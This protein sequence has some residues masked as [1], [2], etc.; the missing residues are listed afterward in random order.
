VFDEYTTILIRI[1]PKDDTSGTYPV[2]ATL[3]DGD[4]YPGGELR[5]DWEQLRLQQLDPLGY[6]RLLADALFAGPI[7]EA[8]ITVASRA[9][10]AA[11]GRVR[12]RLWIDSRAAE[13]HALPWERLY[14][15]QKNKLVP[16]PTT[17]R[18]PFSRYLAVRNG[19][20]Q[21]IRRS[22]IHLLFA[23][24]NPSDLAS[25]LRLAPVDVEAEV[26]NLLQ[27]L[28]ELRSSHRFQVTIMPGQTGLSPDLQSRLEQEGYR[29]REGVTSLDGILRALPGCGLVHF[30]GHGNLGPDGVAVLH[31][32]KEDGTWE[33]VT[34]DE[35][36]TGLAAT[37]PLPHLIFLAACESG[38]R[39][40]AETLSV[41]GE[42]HPF[43]GLA[44]KLLQAGV[45]AVVAMQDVVPMD[46]VRQLTADFYRNLL[47]H[48]QI[49]LAVNQARLLLFDTDKVD[50]AIPVLFSRLIDNDLVDFPSLPSLQRTHELVEATGTLLTAA[51]S[52]AHGPELVEELERLFEGWQKSYQGLA[53]LESALRRTGDNPETFAVRFGEFYHEFKDYYNSETWLDEQSLIQ[54]TKRLR[55]RVLPQMEPQMDGA[56]F[57]QVRDA[58]DQH[59]FA[60]GQLAM[61][62]QEF[63]EAM[64]GVVIEIR[65]RLDSGDVEG[66]IH[67][68]REF[69][70]QHASSLAGSRKLLQMMSTQIMTVDDLVTRME[71]VKGPD[72]VVSK[73]DLINTVLVQDDRQHVFGQI[74]QRVMDAQ[75]V[76]ERVLQSP[77]TADVPQHVASQID[78][79]LAAQRGI[80]ARGILLPPETLH[81]LGMLAAYRRDYDTAVSYFR[82]ATEADPGYVAAFQA[83]A[84][85]QQSRAMHDLK[86]GGYDAALAKLAE[87]RAASSH[88]PTDRAQ[89]S[90]GYIAKTQAQ[91]AA[92]TDRPDDYQSYLQ[93]AARLFQQALEL[94]PHSAE[95]HNG[96]GNIYYML[97]DYDAAVGALDQAVQLNPNYTAAYHDLGAACMAQMGADPAQATKWCQKAIQAF[98]RAYQ[99]SERDPGFSD[100]DRQELCNRIERLRLQC[101]SAQ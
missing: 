84:W 76:D 69:E 25:K 14:H 31:L 40:R 70:I 19:E 57:I 4:F 59:L 35:L 41:R 7:G 10:V 36:T 3:D 12:V 83:I 43:V 79:M 98:E 32:E 89:I 77:G 38:K 87:A 88:I 78:Q 27:A 66:A 75:G 2:E 34:D 73:G 52:Q 95:A 24:A 33:A 20:P 91:I 92:R 22:P 96:M 74:S 50:W 72:Q 39:G 29:I 90:Q 99:L 62:F 45:P 80:G 23:I 63:L 47:I 9:A 8:Y 26:V 42:N 55:N 16:L 58:L 5:L 65:R 51:R 64:D 54:A 82:Q 61:G 28:G 18:T 94:N 11:E 37:Q 100:A 48:G 17:T 85:L 60:R 53:G 46:L 101:G 15:R 21:P 6:G 68:K 71:S 97:R 81:H 44:P 86:A 30:L 67:R 49:D 56:S 13:L 93:E 1:Y